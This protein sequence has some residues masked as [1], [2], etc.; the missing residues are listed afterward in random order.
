[1]VMFHVSIIGTYIDY[2]RESSAITGG[3]RALEQSNFL[4]SFGGKDREYSQQVICVVD[5]DSVQ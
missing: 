3:E 5:G 1:M 2:G 4:H